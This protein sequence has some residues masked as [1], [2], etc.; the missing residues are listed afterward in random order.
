MI[1]QL[2]STLN[3]DNPPDDIARPLQALWWLKKGG[4]V[5]G[6]EWEKAHDLCQQQEGDKHHDWVH[7]LA[8]WIEGDHGNANYWYRRV[9]EDRGGEDIPA[10]W[11]H[12]VK[13]V[14]R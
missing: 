8:H 4:L 1:D 2:V 3:D 11:D 13:N 5:Q 7:A 10:E 14:S 12:I 6:P 9:G